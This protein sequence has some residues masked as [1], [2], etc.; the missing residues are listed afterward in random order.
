MAPWRVTTTKENNDKKA[1]Y[2]VR[3]LEGII[4]PQHHPWRNTRGKYC[5]ILFIFRG[6]FLRDFLKK[7]IPC[8]RNGENYRINIY[9]ID[10][11]H[12]LVV[13]EIIQVEFS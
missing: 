8:I 2:I 7:H 9:V 4:T 13:L 6:C 3:T 11:D 5:N 10:R 1:N 12:K